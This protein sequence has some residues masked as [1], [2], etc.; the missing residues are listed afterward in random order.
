MRVSDYSF[1]EPTGATPR[2]HLLPSVLPARASA[3][4]ENSN[5]DFRRSWSS[6]N[7]SVFWP[8]NCYDI[9]W[10]LLPRQQSPTIKR[11][12]SINQSTSLIVNPC[13][14]WSCVSTATSTTTTPN[15]IAKSSSSSPVFVE[16][17]S[18]PAS[19]VNEFLIENNSWIQF[20]F[21]FNLDQTLLVSKFACTFNW[22]R[23]WVQ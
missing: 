6:R 18:S 22:N 8:F 20:R 7:L 16:S 19:F 3:D 21:T 9:F 15:D 23:T 2:I 4:D 13:R 10:F 11:G 17:V 1:V 12:S 5:I 14:H